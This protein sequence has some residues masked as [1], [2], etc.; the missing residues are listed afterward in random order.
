[1]KYNIVFDFDGVINSYKSGWKGTTNIPDPP[2]PGIDKV[3]KSLKESGN[4]KI[5]IVSSRCGQVGGTEAIADYMRKYKLGAYIDEITAI[6]PAAYVT[7]DDRC[8]QFDG[9]K[10]DSLL[11][12]IENFTPWN[13][14]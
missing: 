1:M 2:V 8:I 3:L 13:K 7:I 11:E 4:Y 5:F 6:K 10:V 9:K 12:Q 14:R